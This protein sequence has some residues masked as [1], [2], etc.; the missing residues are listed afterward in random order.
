MKTSFIGLGIMGSRM[1]ANLLAN[2]FP[3]T[4]W[5]R[6]A[7]ASA[8]LKEKGATVADSLE[9]AVQDAD[10]VFSMLSKPEAVAD[11]FF[12]EA[13]ALS[14]MKKDALWV[15][16]STNNPAFTRQAAEEA[17]S[18]G[19]RFFEAPVAGSKPQAEGA[20]LA[21]FVGAM[22]ADIQPIKPMLEAMG[23]KIVPF[24]KVGQ[25][26]AYKMLVNIMLA[27]SMLVFSEAVLLG[28]KLGIDRELL[29][30]V[31]PDLPVIAPFTKFKTDMIRKDDYPVNFPLELMHKDLHLAALSAYE[32]GQPLILA[33]ATK[34]VYAGALRAGMGREDFAAVHRFL[35]GERD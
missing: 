17:S 27:Q 12:G 4:V 21:F 16:C 15:D 23:Q 24:G 33:N 3:I 8:A 13:G 1:A 20:L 10:V 34:E 2:N 31:V 29:L 7:S 26:S 9:A 18:H 28:E 19:V 25:G 6:T 5:N 22:E 11:C 32:V 14:Q 35:E 30:N